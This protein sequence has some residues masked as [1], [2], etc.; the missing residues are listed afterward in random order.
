MEE[1]EENKITDNEF[2]YHGELTKIEK[3]NDG[4]IYIAGI[5]TTEKMDHDGEI[6][7][8]NEVRKVWDDYMTNPVLKYMHGKDTSNMAAIGVVVPSY[9]D[10]TGKMWKTEFTDEGPFIVCKISNAPDTESIR[11]KVEEGIVKGFSIGGRAKRVKTFDPTLQKD[12]NRVIT[13]RISEIS[14]VDLPANPD[15]FFS[16]LKAACVGDNCPMNDDTETIEKGEGKAPKTWWDNCMGTA[17]GI[18]GMKDASAF[19]GWMWAHGKEDFGPQRSE[20]GKIEDDPIVDQAVAKF[21]ELIVENATLK[22]RLEKL[23]TGLDNMVKIEE[24]DLTVQK[25]ENSNLIE[26][27]L[28]EL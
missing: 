26:I 16:V 15:S 3:S 10:S 14:L 6:V 9:T 4:N 5:C 21:E 18:P 13:T 20:I 7:D 28:H 1:Q 19:C 22:D 27:N 25:S 2:N 11:T 17:K 8:L 12:V 24:E 23:E